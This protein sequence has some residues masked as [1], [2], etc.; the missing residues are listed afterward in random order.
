[1]R[2]RCARAATPRPAASPLAV[3]RRTLPR[4]PHL[5]PHS[6]IAA[7]LVFDH[8]MHMMNLLTRIGWQ[9]CAWRWPTR[10][11]RPRAVA[12]RVAA[13]FVDYL[14]FVD[15]PRLPAPVTA[16]SGFAARSPPGARGPPRPLAAR[17]R[18]ADAAAEISVQLPDLLAGLRR[19]A[20]RWR[21][22][23]S[24]RAC[25]TCSRGPSARRPA[26]R[27]CPAPTAGDRRDPARD[28]ERATAYFLGEVN[29]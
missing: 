12:A 13:D 19:P 9:T 25:G 15:E 6:D 29:K 23:P 4:G 2:S 20:R 27:G 11:R 5:T 26:T 17:S 18:S 28:E 7:L 24:M 3:A 22:T 14:L 21:R 16:Q 10:R 1:M 8:Q